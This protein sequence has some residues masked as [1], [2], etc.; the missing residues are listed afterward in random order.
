AAG[1]GWS[2]STIL[3]R[4]GQHH[5][6]VDL[7]LQN[8]L[9][10]GLAMIVAVIAASGHQAPSLQLALV[11]MWWLVPVVLIIVIPGVFASMWG[12]P[13]LSPGI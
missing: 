10:S 9:W 11:Q 12:A 4:L 1:F 8:F 7:M 3:L 6:A 2:V 5:N 13:K